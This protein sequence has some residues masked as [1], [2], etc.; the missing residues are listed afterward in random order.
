MWYAAAVVPQLNAGSALHVPLKRLEK[1]RSRGLLP[2]AY[3]APH[4]CPPVTVFEIRMAEET[5]AVTKAKTR[6]STC[7]PP[8]GVI[9]ALV[10]VATAPSAIGARDVPTTVT[11]RPPAAAE[12][13]AGIAAPPP[14]MEAKLELRKATCACAVLTRV[15][16]A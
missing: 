15:R 11:G 13:N 16:T 7:R 2:I 8:G 12:R 1:T 10:P 6:S 14:L 9:D 5:L 4:D 3:W